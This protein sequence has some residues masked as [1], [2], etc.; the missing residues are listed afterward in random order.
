MDITTFVILKHYKEFIDR[1]FK[2]KNENFGIHTRY[3]KYVSKWYGSFRTVDVVKG[4]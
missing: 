4:K 1:C 2:V 3:P